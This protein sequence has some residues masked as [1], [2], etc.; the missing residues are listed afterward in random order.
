MTYNFLSLPL[1][2]LGIL[3]KNID[4]PSAADDPAFLTN[5]FNRTAHFHY[6]TLNVILPRVK[7]YG[8]NSSFTRSP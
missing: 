3:A 8:D 4:N 2:M 6:F 5:F 7:S 1:F